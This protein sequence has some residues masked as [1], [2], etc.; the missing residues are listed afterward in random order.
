MGT[1]TR[2]YARGR[3]AG[4]RSGYN[5]RAFTILNSGLGSRSFGL[6]DNDYVCWNLPGH[7]SAFAL[8]PRLRVKHCP[9]G[10]KLGRLAYRLAYNGDVVRRS[11][12]TCGT[13]GTRSRAIRG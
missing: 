3:L 7:R 8:A 12:E 4:L 5:Y 2:A 11:P 6:L 1:A 9:P 10:S 13:V